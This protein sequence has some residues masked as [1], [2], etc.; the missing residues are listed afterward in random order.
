MTTPGFPA[1]R[2][3]FD[4]AD[5]F[6]PAAIAALGGGIAWFSA[7]RPS[8]MPAWGPYEF[9]WLVYL[10]ATLS[11]F[12]FARGLTRTAAADRPHLWRRICFIVGVVAIY[13]VLQTRLEFLMTHMFFMNRI[14]HVV[15]HHFGPFLIAL[16]WAGSTILRGM[17]QPLTQPLQSRPIGILLDILQQP[18]IAAVLFFG[19]V[20]FWLIPPIHF[21]AM[22]DPKLYAVMNWTMILDGVLFWALVLDPRP[23]PPARVSAVWRAIISIIVMFPQI[24]LGAF[25][26]FSGNN[27]YPY[28]D[29]CG[30]IYPSIGAMT[31][32]HFGALIIWIPPAMM[33][34]VGLLVVLNTI[35]LN[36]DKQKDTQ[37]ASSPLGVSAS[38]WTGR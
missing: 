12:W 38:R 26:A 8:L 24:A 16:G 33:S 6:G 29:L 34:V 17:P 15:M 2:P 21:R 23:K 3:G 11:L 10:A 25:I 27:L 32:Q 36:E 20:I 14:Q 37:D 18:V 28:Y 19:L 1:A 13:A 22:I 30:R 7:E 31:D 5:V 9:S 4:A 35:R